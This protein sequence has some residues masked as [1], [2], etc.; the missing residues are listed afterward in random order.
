MPGPGL[1]PDERSPQNR[2]FFLDQHRP[3]SLIIGKFGKV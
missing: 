3:D 1:S 2:K